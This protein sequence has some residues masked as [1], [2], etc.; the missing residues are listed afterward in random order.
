MAY[1]ICVDIKDTKQENSKMQLRKIDRVSM[2]E[3]GSRPE[4]DGLRGNDRLEEYDVNDRS[5]WAYEGLSEKGFDRKK[6]LMVAMKDKLLS[7]RNGAE[8]NEYGD[9]KA[10]FEFPSAWGATLRFFGMHEDEDSE[11][12]FAY[13]GMYTKGGNILCKSIVLASEVEGWEMGR[14]QALLA[15]RMLELEY[16]EGKPYWDEAHVVV[17]FDDDSAIP[18][19]A[20]EEGFTFCKVERR[21]NASKIEL[22]AIRA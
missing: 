15:N 16:L 8:Y 9:E 3:K 10:P 4:C 18:R 13:M 1:S 6:K 20:S 12:P 11:E 5:H 22:D 7:E 2:Y 17:M 19:V 14:I 21:V